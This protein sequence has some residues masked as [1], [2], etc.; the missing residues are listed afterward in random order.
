MATTPPGPY[1]AYA[2]DFDGTLADTAALNHAA[3]RAALAEHG[4]TVT[5]AW[6][7]AE[8]T[9]TAGQVRR[10]LALPPTTLPDETFVA[11]A[12]AHWFA[13]TDRIRP[14][15]AAAVAARAAADRAPI[16]VV[17][18]NFS[19]VVRHG[20]TVV[21]MGDLPWTVVGRDDVTHTKPAPDAYLH[22]ARI[23]GVEPARCLA[24]EDT[25]EGITAATKAG[26]RVVDIRHRPWQ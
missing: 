26:M 8:P 13:H 2:F 15:A 17:S 19:D 12:R 1:D 16:A 25:D 23:M 6:V 9:V 7:A 5:L 14:I 4:I 24:H 20:L 11:A 22:A 21:G 18:A 10:R 3:V